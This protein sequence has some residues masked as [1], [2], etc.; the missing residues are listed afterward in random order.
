M[1]KV[2]SLP[3]TIKEKST[4]Q[5]KAIRREVTINFSSN[6][7]NNWS[8]FNSRLKME[9][10]YCIY[11]YGKACK[12]LYSLRVLRKAGVEVKNM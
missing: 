4:F 2:L 8:D 7:N 12:R 9:R 11:I 5:A 10:T 6:N 3:E 1:V